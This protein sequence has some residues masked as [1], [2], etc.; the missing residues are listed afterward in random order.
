MKG[1]V[2]KRVLALGA[3]AILVVGCLS[4]CGGSKEETKQESAEPASENTETSDAGSDS[5]SGE[6]LKIGVVAKYQHEFYEELYAGA[7]AAA[8][9]IGAEISCNNPATPDLVEEHVQM[10]EDF[11]AKGVDILVVVPAQPDS[12]VSA[13]DNA[14]EKGITLVCADTNMPNYDNKLCFVG[15]SNKEAAYQVGKKICE[16]LEKG[17]NVIIIRGP[18]GDTTAEQRNSGVMRAMEEAGMNVLE[19]YDGQSDSAVCAAAVEDFLLKYNKQGI[20]AVVSLDSNTALGVTTAIANDGKTGQI[21]V[22]G[23]DA[24]QAMLE[25]VKSGDALFDCAQN[26][27][28]MGYE[29]VMAAYKA[30]NGEDV[31]SVIDT[32]IT[33]ITQENVDDYMK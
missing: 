27:Y 25:M 11:I 12:L 21:K 9:E 6:K 31:E 15:T 16:S 24:A 19:S 14:N 26:P 30:R 32:G 7:R 20:D 28:D 33:M 4:G 13:F 18:L 23:F 1:K 3:A 8:E 29:S 2:V 17:S 5:T 10:C 22:N